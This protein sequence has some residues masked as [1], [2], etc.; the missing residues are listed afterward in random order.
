MDTDPDTAHPPLFAR[1]ARRPRLT[2]LLDESR[3][4]ALVITGPAGYGKTILATEWLQGREQV[5]WYRATSASADV[6]AFSAGLA[7][8]VAPLVPGA[9]QHL[10]QRLRVA[11]SPE[12]AA[13]PLAELLAQDLEGW[14][15]AALLVIDDYHLVADSAPV[16]D[17]FDWL[18][19][20]Q[21]K[22]R[23]LVTTRRRPRWASARRILYGEIT[24]IGGDQL[25]MNAD[26]A[27]RVLGADRS[28]E[29]IRALVTQAEGWPA[30]I[31]L[32]ALTASSEMPDERVSE[33][34]YRYFA[35]ELVRHEP[36]DVQR[37]M[38]VASVPAM[39]DARIAREVLDVADP[40]PLLDALAGQGLLLRI[41]VGFQ[42]HPLLRSFL[43]KRLEE[44]DPA[45]L[46]ALNERAISDSRTNARWEEAF[47]S[48]L[49]AGQVE[50]AVGVLV[51][52]MSIL[53]A[54]GRIETLER[55]LDDCGS[56]A[57]HSAGAT[58]ASVE[59]LIR[60]GQLLDASA[61]A[62]DLTG[63]L[64]DGHP[65]ASR[66]N[67]LAGQAM[68]LGSG[69]AQAVEFQKRARE[70]AQ[71]EE[72][73]KRALW[74]LFMTENELGSPRAE[75][76]LVE[77]DAMTTD[78]V[79][80][81]TRLR[82]A[83]GR[84]AVAAN[85]GSFGDLLEKSLPLAPMSAHASDP[86]AR[87]TF[88]VNASYLCVAHADYKRAL[89]IAHGALEECRILGLEFAR[90]Y[91]LATIALAHAGVRA[92]RSAQQALRE[93]EG[94]ADEQD[95]LYLRWS[96]E[97]TAIRVALARGRPDEALSGRALDFANEIPVPAAQGEYL[98]V[99]GLA[100]AASGDQ[101]LVGRCVRLAESRTGAIE[102]RFFGQFADLISKIGIQEPSRPEVTRLIRA[103]MN[104]SFEDSFVVA[105]RLAPG[106]LDLIPSDDSVVPAVVLVMKR[107]NDH[108][109]ARSHFPRASPAPAETPLTPREEEVL[110]LLATGL[111]NAEI[112]QRLFISLSTAKVHV[113]HILKKLG[114][115]TRLQ[116]AMHAATFSDGQD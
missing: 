86:M 92:F 71:G 8:V 90:G 66:A 51:D 44:I 112:A 115:K 6:A 106:L 82:I 16:E 70:L 32:A 24:E 3:A 13:R 39:I 110:E 67:F 64:P 40:E 55:W 53:L 19:T 25:A 75:G 14:P 15:P 76:L 84:Q 80:L 69:S 28:G 20:L 43:R 88:L 22:L 95:N 50:A 33:A 26:E 108:G 61:I 85:R 116:A 23:V 56:H 18:L 100:A 72:D 107:A 7:D 48:A 81:D 5:V 74:G 99:L 68:Y 103:A 60:K 65:L 37:F 87:T 94:V 109:I 102:A 96:A 42:F 45:T 83:V 17:F 12:R 31:G 27:R 11:D 41:D 93:L 113:Q 63:R 78:S 91:C 62:Q 59:I 77:L 46:K 114:A 111:S 10:K 98:A 52:A 2:R 30:L 35:E 89:A 54:S 4:Q 1:H 38:L 58:I 79:D 101:D 97:I 29:S 105:Y 104:A 36:P 49:E 73:I 9:G 21:P 57:V 47:S 34:L